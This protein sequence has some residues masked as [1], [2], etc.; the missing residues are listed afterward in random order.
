M[1]LSS[2][3][4][5]S[6]RWRVAIGFR[7][8]IVLVRNALGVEVRSCRSRPLA[9]VALLTAG[10]GLEAGRATSAGSGLGAWLCSRAVLGLSLQVNSRSRWVQQGGAFDGQHFES[11]SHEALLHRP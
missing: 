8:W 3:P 4:G 5:C 2:L 1:G 6:G 11:S 7:P 10:S 9:P